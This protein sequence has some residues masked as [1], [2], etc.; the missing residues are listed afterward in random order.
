MKKRPRRPQR[1]RPVWRLG[2][3]SLVSQYGL[4]EAQGMPCQAGWLFA[5]TSLKDSRLS[6]PGRG[7]SG[8]A[9]G[10]GGGGR[11]VEGSPLGRPRPASPGSTYRAGQG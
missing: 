2:P 6:A 3:A 7:A 9:K 1:R 8:P 10:R 11:G 4:K 5:Q